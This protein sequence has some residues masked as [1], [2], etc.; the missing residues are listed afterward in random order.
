MEQGFT[1]DQILVEDQSKNTLQ[2]MRFSK[3]LIEE[4]NLKTKAAFSTT[5]FHVFRSGI[6][7]R[8]NDFEP[9]GMGAPTKWYFWPNAYMRE[10]IGMM[11]FKWKSIIIVMIPVILFFISIQFV[12]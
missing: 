1:E 5:N 4:R 10:V 9:D 8:Q 11:A 2:N 7:S 3:K 12:L 6:I